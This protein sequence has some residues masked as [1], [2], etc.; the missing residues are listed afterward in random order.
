MAKDEDWVATRM[1]GTESRRSE[2]PLR[3]LHATPRQRGVLVLSF[4]VC[5]AAILVL[6]FLAS[7]AFSLSG[8]ALAPFA[9]P[10]LVI[11]LEWAR[12]FLTR[13]EPSAG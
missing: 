13:E 12:R 11:W 10:P 6:T 2:P 3:E 4:I 7:T 9:L 5:L 8:R 1:A